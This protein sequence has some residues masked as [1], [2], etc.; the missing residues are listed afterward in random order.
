MTDHS[1]QRP[2]AR[3]A[4]TAVLCTAV[5]V[6]ATAL[7][8]FAPLPLRFSAVAAIVSL[9]LSLLL[10]LPGLRQQAARPPAQPAAFLVPAA[11]ATAILA[12]ATL[13]AIATVRL[14]TL[15]IEL[16]SGTPATIAGPS[17]FG[18]GGLLVWLALTISAALLLVST[19]SPLSGTILFALAALGTIWT[20][21]LVPVHQ[22]TPTGGLTRG[23]G[24]PVLATG[25]AAVLTA[26]VITQALCASSRRTRLLRSD[27]RLTLAPPPAWPGFA[28]GCAAVG[29][30]LVTIVCYHL[31]VGAD[32]QPLGPRLTALL[33][34]AVSGGSGVALLFLAGRSW[35]VGLAEIGMGLICLAACC[36]A[37]MAVPAEPAALTRRYPLLF[38]AML[39]AL[40]LM[41]WLWSWLSCVWR[42]QLD[43]GR[44]WTTAG[45]MIAPATRVSFSCGGVALVVTS[46]M[47]AWPRLATVGTMDHT[48]PRVAAGV[49]GHLFLLLA[50]LWCARHVRQ[51]RFVALAALTVLSMLAFVFVRT[52][53]LKTAAF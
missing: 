34:T 14:M 18:P 29:L 32:T 40:A 3:S 46:A 27:P 16:S 25:L 13:S 31:G 7:T 42:Q 36:A 24:A 10:C 8:G 48:L 37:T 5:V 41:T 15:A 19:R 2:T 49:A 11:S 30:A 4:L 17:G 33:L 43:E 28:T 47:T 50:L 22:A 26:A 51:T 21:L 6:A 23:A 39:F 9:A 44:A 52:V 12:G 38:N 35:G 1:P 53:P 45:R 20:A